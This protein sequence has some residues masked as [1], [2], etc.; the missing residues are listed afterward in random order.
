MKINCGNKINYSYFQRV[1]IFI[2]LNESEYLIVVILTRSTLNIRLNTVIF[3]L[4]GKYIYRIKKL[5]NTS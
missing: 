3:L 5:K 4:F 2:Y 1:F